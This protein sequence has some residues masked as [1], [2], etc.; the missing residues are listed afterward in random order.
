MDQVKIFEVT[1]KEFEPNTY[2]YNGVRYEQSYAWT[3]DDKKA[4][5]K[6][7]EKAYNETSDFA[8]YTVETSN[9]VVTVFSERHTE[10][11]RKRLIKGY[12]EQ[13]IDISNDMPTKAVLTEPRSQMS[14][15]DELI[16]ELPSIAIKPKVNTELKNYDVHLRNKEIVTFTAF[17]YEQRSV[18][19]FFF[20]GIEPPESFVFV[21]EVTAIKWSKI[22]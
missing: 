12:I 13:S 19:F 14:E 16:E 6:I 5:E 18:K 22:V 8:E 2:D 1:F 7:V 20:D 4:I 21:S 11:S 10:Y 9:G 15:D 17:G 3:K